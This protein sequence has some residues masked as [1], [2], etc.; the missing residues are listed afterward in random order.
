[1]RTFHPEFSHVRHIEDPH[2]MADR[3]VFINDSGIFNRHVVTCKFMHLGTECNVL[4][5]K[6]S[7]FHK[8][9]FKVDNRLRPACDFPTG[10]QLQ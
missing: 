5:G 3:Q 10:P 6:W 2:R 9:Y 8:I 7:C 4:L 1:M